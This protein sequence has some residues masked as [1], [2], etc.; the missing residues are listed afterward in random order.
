MVYEA[1]IMMMNRTVMIFNP[2]WWQ[3]PKRL[4]VQSSQ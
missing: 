4:P 1:M 2:Q 3:I